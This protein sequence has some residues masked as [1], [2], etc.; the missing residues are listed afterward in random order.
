VI[1]NYTSTV[2][3]ERTIAR[4]EQLLAKAG[5]VGIQ[6]EYASG[7]PVAMIFTVKAPD[8]DGVFDVR[9]PVSV[10]P[11]YKS[12]NASRKRNAWTEAAQKADRQQAE[13]TAWKLIQDWIEV[14]LSLIQLR[15]AEL[16]QVFMPYLYDGKRTMFEAMKERGFKALPA[17]GQTEAQA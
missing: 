5:A 6:K 1:K 3:V 15:Q 9:V 7:K 12:I 2:D 17:P 14:Q 10:E 11:V 8:G 16:L 4:I 13:R